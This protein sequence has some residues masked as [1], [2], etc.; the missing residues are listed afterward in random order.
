MRSGGRYGVLDTATA[1]DGFPPRLERPIAFQPMQY[2]IDH[3]F[4]DCDHRIGT[5]TDGLNDLIA[6]HLLLLE[7]P[8]DQKLRNP[9]HKIRIGSACRHREPTI[10][11][12]SMYGKLITN[13]TV[14]TLRMPSSFAYREG[15]V[16]FFA[17]FNGVRVGVVVI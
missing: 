4:A 14:A 5:A 2:R 3:A 6:V 8:E 11:C 17:A 9:I 1:V 12:G 15:L 16:P 10:P 13:E 7:E